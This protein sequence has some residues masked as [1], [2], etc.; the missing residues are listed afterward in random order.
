M[1]GLPFF[2]Y[3]AAN[4]EA[5]VECAE[6]LDDEYSKYTFFS[7]LNYRLTGDANILSLCAVGRNTDR[8]S[9]DSYAINRTFFELGSK[10][11]FVDG[12]AFDGN[13]IAQFLRAV[14][15][16]FEHIF[17]F[18]PFADST[19]K[20]RVKVTELAR[21]YGNGIV[22]RISVIEKGLWDSTATLEFNP[23]LFVGDDKSLEGAHPD[24]GHIVD[25]GIMNYIYSEV[26]ESA[27][28]K[29]I[30]TTTIDSACTL[31]VTLIKLE[32][33][34]SELRALVGASATIGR[35]RP[36]LAISVYHKPEDLV[37]LMSFVRDTGLDYKLDLRQHNPWV[38]D[39]MVCYCR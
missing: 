38:P 25:G 26:Q 21:I 14:N 27:H 9:Y 36:R 8:F 24:S 28:A 2:E 20:C 23:D 16:E 31:P 12:G 32:I 33:E 6:W 17:S 15:G 19:A 7:I 4:C 34:G 39:A 5:H 13:T 37:T 29:Y 35:C 18:E 10:E 11:V 22:D 1:Y 30:E 3:A